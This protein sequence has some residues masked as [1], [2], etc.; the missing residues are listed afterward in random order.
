MGQLIFEMAATLTENFGV[1][2]NCPILIAGAM[3]KAISAA[4]CL[5]ARAIS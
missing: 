5:F 3:A 4:A 1:G 2:S